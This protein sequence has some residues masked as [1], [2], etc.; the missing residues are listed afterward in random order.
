MCGYSMC[1]SRHRMLSG[2]PLTLCIW[3]EQFAFVKNVVGVV[4]CVASW[5]VFIR[6]WMKMKIDTKV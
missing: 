3:L 4:A 2:N 6:P 1:V 5:L